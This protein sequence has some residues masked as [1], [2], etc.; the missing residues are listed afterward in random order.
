MRGRRHCGEEHRYSL[1]DIVEGG[2]IMDDEDLLITEKLGKILLPHIH[3]KRKA[4]LKN[5]EEKQLFFHYTSAEA[6]LSILKEK[7]FWLRNVRNMNDENEIKYGIELLQKYLNTEKFNELKERIGSLFDDETVFQESINTINLA[8]SSAFMSPHFHTY[9]GCLSHINEDKY[10]ENENKYGRL[11]MW[12]AFGSSKSSPV[13][14]VVKLPEK[15][16]EY[17]NFSPVSYLTSEEFSKLFQEIIEEINQFDKKDNSLK[18]LEKQKKRNWILHM[19]ISIMSTT[20]HPIFQEEKEWRLI[21]TSH[22]Y[23]KDTRLEKYTK[24]I[25]GTPQIIYKIPLKYGE[26]YVEIDKII[27]GPSS[28]SETLQFLFVEK[29]QDFGIKDAENRVIISGISDRIL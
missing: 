9:I 14:I 7:Q 27:I 25:K 22:F 18:S 1:S 29:L 2:L 15:Q 4:L 8:L 24:T 10:F 12:R 5:P 13:A 21:Y 26:S 3:K 6:A 16:R 11:S 20:K 17:I 19:V 23:D 28:Y